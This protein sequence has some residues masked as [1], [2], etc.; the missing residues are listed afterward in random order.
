M[1]A[2]RSASTQYFSG[3]PVALQGAGG[4]TGVRG[5][6]DQTGAAGSGPRWGFRDLG[7]R[8]PHPGSY[9]PSPRHVPVRAPA[10]ATD[11][12]GPGTGTFCGSPPPF[13]ARS[14][15]DSLTPCPGERGVRGGAHLSSWIFFF[16]RSSTRSRRF[17]A[18]SWRRRPS[19]KVATRSCT[20]FCWFSR[21]WR[22]SSSACRRRPA[23]FFSASS[24]SFSVCSL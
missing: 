12:G 13:G 9:N 6:W 14:R 8:A 2:L 3:R 24:R 7:A 1:L 5:P 22:R 15:P 20:C 11:P 16:L 18:S 17:R 4:G 21:T 19:S 23:A 10:P